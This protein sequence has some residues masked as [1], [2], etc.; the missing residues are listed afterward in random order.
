MKEL[1][2]MAASLGL[3]TIVSAALLGSVYS[4]TRTPIA[5]ARE[6]KLV[7]A[8]KA[9]AP[10]F[11]NNP[12]ADVTELTLP[13]ESRPVTIY[14]ARDNGTLTG[15]AV[16]TYTPDGFSGEITL[17]VGF[18][19]EGTVT[20]FEVLSH[21]ETPGLGAKMQDWFADPKGSRSIIG[22]RPPESGFRVTKDPGGEIDGIT[23]ATIT[24][25]AFLQ[26]IN[27]AHKAFIAYSEQ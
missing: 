25:R 26:A 22:K 1:L 27:R 3:I 4:A 21:S 18:D 9:V 11:N 23:A 2:K 8:I 6:E 15:A 10:A 7:N 20:G 16:A 14:P 13:G 5:E 17:M 24:S 12:A 19:T